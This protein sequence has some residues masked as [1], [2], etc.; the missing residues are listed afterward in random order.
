MSPRIGL[1]VP[2]PQAVMERFITDIHIELDTI[3]G[4]TYIKGESKYLLRKVVLLK[5][6]V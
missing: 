6:V 2:P 5:D 4:S 1:K 3:E